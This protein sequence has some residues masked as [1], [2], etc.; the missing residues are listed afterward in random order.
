M[1]LNKEVLLKH[2]RSIEVS[3]YL[4]VLCQGKTDFKI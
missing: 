4:T 3:G 1:A 2:L